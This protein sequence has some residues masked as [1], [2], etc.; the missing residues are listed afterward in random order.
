MDGVYSCCDRTDSEGIS[1]I[2]SVGILD[3]SQAIY[4]CVNCV[5]AFQNCEMQLLDSSCS[6]LSLSI[7]PLRKTYLGTF[8][9]FSKISLEN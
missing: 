7:R 9:D 8:V 5:I 2:L 6:S 1:D 3:I 4:I